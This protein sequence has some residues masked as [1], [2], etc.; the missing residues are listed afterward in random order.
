VGQI[1]KHTLR[2]YRD[3]SAPGRVCL[4]ELAEEVLALYH[5]RIEEERI[6]VTRRFE[7]AGEITGLAGELRQILSN[8]LVNALD[9]TGK[10][11]RVVVHIAAGRDW[12]TG[13]PGMRVTV[14]D[15][16]R[17]IDREDRP[18]LFHPFF[19]TKG[20]RGTGLGLWVSAGIAER[21]GGRIRV[22]SSTRPGRSGTAFAIWLPVHAAGEDQHTQRQLRAR[23][24]G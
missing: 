20:D 19:S 4:S 12:R 23:A 7:V 6:R 8:L 22:Y 9:A 17:G 1:T 13:K 5:R 24:A 15:N 14:A 2:F 10:H 3:S 16:G 11:G 18:R 21:H